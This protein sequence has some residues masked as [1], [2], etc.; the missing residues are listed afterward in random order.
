MTPKGSNVI[1]RHFYAGLFTYNGPGRSPGLMVFDPFGV[2]RYYH[3]NF[4][5]NA[6]P[7]SSNNA[8][9]SSGKDTTP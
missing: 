8:L 3:K 1:A 6:T 2:D 5:S 7:C 9:Y 4:S